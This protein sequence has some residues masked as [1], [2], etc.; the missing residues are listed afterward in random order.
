MAGALP[1][2]LFAPLLLRLREYYG[3]NFWAKPSM[4]GTLL[5]YFSLFFSGDRRGLIL[6][7]GLIVL[8]LYAAASRKASKEGSGDRKENPEKLPMEERVLI[9][10]LLC[11]PWIVFAAA[12]AGHGG[13]TWRYMLPT[14]L[15]GALALGFAVDRISGSAK[16]LLLIFLLMDYSLSSGEL[17]AGR[18]SL[19]TA[20]A[21]ATREVET[22]AAGSDL[23]IVV[24][25]GIR[26]LPMAYYVPAE[27]RGRLFAIADPREAVLDTKT[28]SVDL[29]LLVLRH[30]FPLQVEDYVS[31]LS[32]HR[33]FLLVTDKDPE[34]LPARLA[35]DGYEFSP[36]S[37]DGEA[38]VYKVTARP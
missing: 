22:I 23:P 21:S 10:M 25:S 31:F 2:V 6:M 20:R 15:G 33:E 17:F 27:S 24:A 34:W 38:T 11:F 18:D 26:Y 3:Q 19:L 9:L 32:K 37:S 35:R 16:L 12:T 1:F 14:V 5:S 13:M 7:S 4:A 30:Y 28:D 29:A 8:L 36:V